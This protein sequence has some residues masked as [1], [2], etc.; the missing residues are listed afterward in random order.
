M[1]D[2]A[3]TVWLGVCSKAFTPDRPDF[4]RTCV[5]VNTRDGSLRG[6]GCFGAKFKDFIQLDSDRVVAMQFFQGRL[7]FQSVL[8][9]VEVGSGT[10]AGGGSPTMGCTSS[11][12][13]AASLQEFDAVEGITASP[14]SLYWAV[15]LSEGATID[16]L[17]MDGIPELW[18]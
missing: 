13:Q 14:D 17:M 3:G 15:I 9:D 11:C 2:G 18:A 12:M 16:G 10:G 5:A 4:K 6:S 1:E 7:A 8:M